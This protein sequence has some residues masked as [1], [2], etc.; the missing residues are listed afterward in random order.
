MKLGIVSDIHIG[1]SYLLGRLDPTTQLNSRLIDFSN[2]FDSIIDK[3]V[4]KDVEVVIIPGDCYETRHPTSEQLNVF[5]K[6]LHRA[7]A[8][9]LKIFIV[10][11]N[12]DILSA[13]S[14]TTLD[15]FK[16]LHVP[17]I[18]IFSNFAS[19]TLYDE[20]NK[21]I[22][23]IFMPFRDRRMMNTRTVP[24]AIDAVEKKI[25]GLC[26]S[27]S[28]LKLGVGHFM[29]DKPIVGESWAPSVN[30]LILPINL[31]NQFDAVVMGHVHRH[32]ILKEK[33][34]LIIYAGSMERVSFG[35]KDH[36]KVSLIFDTGDLIHPEIIESSVRNIYEISL[37]YSREDK[38]YKGQITDKIIEDIDKFNKKNSIIDS[39]VRLIVKIQENDLYHINQN[40]LKEHFTNK[41]VNYLMPLQ[42]SSVNFRNLRNK[43][44]TEDLDGKKAMS[45]YIQSLVE[46]EHIKQRI[47]KLANKVIDEVEK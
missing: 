1:G 7:I 12:H 3:F 10:C 26:S 5:S 21:P 31:F 28:G 45:S 15:I 34:P 35:E 25:S 6:C 44:I 2:T 20:Y 36:K 13:T 14:T 47:I 42:I 4:E 18:S 17:N 24:E 8:K 16:S 11:G 39:V 30:G 37:D 29:V 32:A 23:L 40:K 19:H 38:S 9:N 22:N 33:D 27:V 46:P 43:K 41:Q